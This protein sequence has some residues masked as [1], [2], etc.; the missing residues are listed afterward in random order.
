MSEMISAMEAARRLDIS[1][2]TLRRGIIDGALPG[3][4]I[5]GTAERMRFII[6]EKALNFYIETGITPM[7]L[8][9]AVC[10]AETIEQGIA[11]IREVLLGEGG[12]YE[13]NCHSE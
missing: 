12:E 1:V 13:N 9:Q 8:A 4:A 6:P 7:M 3:T 10:K 11:I 5:P 2:A